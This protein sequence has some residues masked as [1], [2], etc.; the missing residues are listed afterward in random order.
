MARGTYLEPT[1]TTVAAFLD[2]WLDHKRTQIS[3]RAFE[4]YGEVARNIVPL[5]G[6]VILPKLQP[7]IIAQLY[8]AA[9]KRL[10]PRS[11]HMMHRL[12]SQA[13]KQAVKWHLLRSNPCAAVVPPRVERRQMH[14]LDAD[15]AA[16]LIEA[17]RPRSMFMP[18][19]LGVMCGLRRGE[20][21]ALKWRDVDF[22]AARLRIVASAEQ[23]KQGV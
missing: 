9:L 11:V 3:P 1:S 22:D 19:L 4:C 17:A 2:H 8:V 12:L 23:T 5:I 18:V 20:A 13:L 16:A 10:S 6:S 7:A 15:G 21:A 14:V